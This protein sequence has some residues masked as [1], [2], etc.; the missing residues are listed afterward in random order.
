RAIGEFCRKEKIDAWYLAVPHVEIATS[1]AQ[2][3]SWDEAAEGLRSLGH[4]DE[5]RELSPPEVQALCR[6][7]VFRAGALQRTAAT[8]QPARLAFGLRAALLARGVRVH[9]DSEALEV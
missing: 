7:P 5:L 9:E 3:G 4:A 8:V 2:D 1:R 6:S